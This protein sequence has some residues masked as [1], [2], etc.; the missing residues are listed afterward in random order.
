[1]ISFG[2]YAG[3]GSYGGGG[4]SRSGSVCTAA[5]PVRVSSAT[6]E[7]ADATV[8]GGWGSGV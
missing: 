3:G 4:K 7:A 8:G 6:P 1:M 5:V 2:L